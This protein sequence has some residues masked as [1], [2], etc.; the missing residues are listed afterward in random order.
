MQP[1]IS[2]IPAP[3]DRAAQWCPGCPHPRP[4]M[5]APRTRS[6]PEE[7]V[8][9]LGVRWGGEQIDLLAETPPPGG[10]EHPIEIGQ[11]G[12]ILNREAH[13]IEDRGLL[14]AGAS[15]F[16]PGNNLPQLGNR[17]IGVFGLNLIGVVLAL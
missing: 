3:A 5:R 13:G 14:L 2:A 6:L 12:E 11:R 9:V 17:I 10:I 16:A 4:G 1:L 8:E 15:W 7:G